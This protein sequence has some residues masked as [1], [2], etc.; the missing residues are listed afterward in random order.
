MRIARTLP[1]LVAL[2][3]IGSMIVASEAL[4]GG[5]QDVS[6][7]KPDFETPKGSTLD[8]KHTPKIEAPSKVTAGEWFEVKISI[9]HRKQHPSMVEH[10]V[11]WISLEADGVEINRAYLHPTMSAPMVTFTVALPDAR[12]FN[13]DGDVKSRKDR[14]VTLRA[15]ETPTHASQFWSE[16]KV[17]VTAAK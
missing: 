6:L 8:D 1:L 16:H 10:H 4:A 15:I 14:V 12:T 5:G 9:G 13:K 2:L 7:I 17:T 11:R 3:S